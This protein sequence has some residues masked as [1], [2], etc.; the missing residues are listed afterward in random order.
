MSTQY[1]PDSWDTQFCFPVFLF[2]VIPHMLT[3]Y[4]FLEICWKCFWKIFIW[5]PKNIFGHNFFLNYYFIIFIKMRNV[6]IL[7]MCNMTQIK[8]TGN[9]N[10]VVCTWGLHSYHFYGQEVIIRLFQNR[11]NYFLHSAF[12]YHVEMGLACQ[13]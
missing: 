10:C 13:K 6:S 12:G 4:A 3:H 5:T 11:I 1:S 2:C 8:T 7:N 9:Q